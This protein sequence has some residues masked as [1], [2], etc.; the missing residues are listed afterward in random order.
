MSDLRRK[1]TQRTKETK[2]A[3][4]EAFCRL[5]ITKPINKILITEVCRIAGYNRSTF[6]Q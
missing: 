3:L 1:Q 2:R 5:Y 6:Y 4:K